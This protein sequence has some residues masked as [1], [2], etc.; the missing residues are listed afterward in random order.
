MQLRDCGWRCRRIGG[1]SAGRGDELYILFETACY[2]YYEGTDGN[3]TCDY[4]LDKIVILDLASL[5]TIEILRFT[6]NLWR[7]YG[8]FVSENRDFLDK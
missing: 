4:P 6:A 5:F 7:I 3:G 8:E 2:K 1:D